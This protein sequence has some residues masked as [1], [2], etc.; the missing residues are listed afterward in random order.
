MWG[1]PVGLV[2]AAVGFNFIP[3]DAAGEMIADGNVSGGAVL[4]LV[5]IVLFVGI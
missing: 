5:S 4:V 2:M 3:K 1:M